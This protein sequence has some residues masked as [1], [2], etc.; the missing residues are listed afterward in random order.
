[1]IEK[2]VQRLIASFRL[3]ETKEEGGLVLVRRSLG[4]VGPRSEK[5]HVGSFISFVFLV[6]N[7]QQ[8]SE[9]LYVYCFV[10]LHEYFY[11]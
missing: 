6:F 7:W 5:L 1:M 3:S 10:L 8:F 4:P 11:V 2:V 9:E